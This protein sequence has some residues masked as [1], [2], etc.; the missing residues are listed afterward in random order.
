MSASGSVAEMSSEETKLFM[1]LFNGASTKQRKIILA[2]LTPNQCRILR[3]IFYNIL[4]NSSMKDTLST[5]DKS[6]LRKHINAVK[7]L[8]S[9]KICRQDKAKI[10]QTK[11]ALVKRVLAITD[12]YLSTGS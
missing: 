1:S 9:R 11:Y 2:N 5:P 6:Y 10:Y 3:T 12:S 4:V 8:A 7:S